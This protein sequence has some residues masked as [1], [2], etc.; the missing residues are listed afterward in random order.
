[1]VSA[2]LIWDWLQGKRSCAAALHR[3]QN[4]AI[5]QRARHGLD[6]AKHLDGSTRR[7]RNNFSSSECRRTRFHVAA[8]AISVDAG[9]VPTAAYLEYLQ[10]SF[11]SGVNAVFWYTS[12]DAIYVYCNYTPQSGI[13]RTLLRTGKSLII[14]RKF[15][16]ASFA[17]K[18]RWATRR[19]LER[20]LLITPSC[21]Q[22]E[23]CARQTALRNRP[24]HEIQP[25]PD[26]STWRCTAVRLGL[27]Q[28]SCVG[29][30]STRATI[31]MTSS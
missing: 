7:I 2:L 14:A 12:L 26:R 6:A 8:I 23:W 19:L 18:S 17:E 13:K 11:L 20:W 30:F 16:R 10:R 22:S 4:I 3:L 15:F 24:W 9:L 27:H 5:L 21:H 25:T 29:V 31:H 28:P 1:M